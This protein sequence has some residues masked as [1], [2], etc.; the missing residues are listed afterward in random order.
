MGDPV[1][2]LP[3]PNRI[4]D[5]EVPWSSDQVAMR[6]AIRVIEEALR[7]FR[8]PARVVEVNEGPRE[9][10]YTVE[11][12]TI[13]RYARRSHSASIA[14]IKRRA[15]DL[16]VA[17]ASPNISIQPAASGREAVIISVPHAKPH[18]VTLRT[19]IMSQPFAAL[20]GRLRLALGLGAGGDP[21][22][23]DLRAM[24]HVLVGG[25]AGSG[26][27]TC[28]HAFIASLLLHNAPDVLNLLAI[29]TKMV[30]L[31]L[32]D[33]I[34][35]L[36][37]AVITEAPRATSALQVI[38]AKAT[39]RLEQFKALG[40]RDITEY[41]RRSTTSE[42]PRLPFIVVILDDIAELVA[43]SPREL[44]G[45]LASLVADGRSA[46]I[47]LIAST[48]RPSDDAVA[49]SITGNFPGRIAFRVASAQDSRILLD[50]AGAEKLASRGD[51]LFLAPDASDPVRVQGAF[52]SDGEIR[53]LVDHWRGAVVVSPPEASHDALQSE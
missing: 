28:I 27:S 24:P 39:Q 50:R 23:L 41:K 7:S 44:A 32:Y 12:D 6:R 49:R 21:V 14:S 51:M 35:H 46:G 26:K 11:P 1:W 36:M 31:G 25:T 29:D 42:L 37:T 15:D 18:S 13:G 9:T 4:L 38:R 16:A 43:A 3:T 34:P 52:V 47:H 2:Q 10:L 45:I 17:L 20:R 48:S 22:A 8:I 40:V 30:E 53:R 19:V 5:P 33:G